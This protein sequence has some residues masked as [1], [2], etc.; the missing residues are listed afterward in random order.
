MMLSLFAVF[1]AA[2]GTYSPPMAYRSLGQAVRQFQQEARNPDSAV[3]R[4]LKDYS[5]FRVGAYDDNSGL[6]IPEQAPVSVMAALEA[7]KSD[8]M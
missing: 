4:S 7:A 5:L 3:G 6:V 1:D 8:L 2:V